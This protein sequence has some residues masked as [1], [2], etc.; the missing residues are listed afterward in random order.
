M[1]GGSGTRFWPMSKKSKPK[2]FLD[3]LGT[4]QTL[5][6][7]TFD[8]FAAY[9]P[10]ENIFIVSNANYAQIIKDQLPDI[11]SDQVLLEPFQRN[12]AP[13]IAYACYKTTSRNYIP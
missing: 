3:V 11:G 5:L 4:G 10:K 9:V 7:M 8:R 6:Q 13:C 12:T 1:A 2:Q